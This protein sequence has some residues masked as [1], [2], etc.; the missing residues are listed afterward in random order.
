MAKSIIELGQNLDVV[1][2]RYRFG[3]DTNSEEIVDISDHMNVCHKIWLMHIPNSANDRLYV[4]LDGNNPISGNSM[5]F[6]LNG[7]V[8]ELEDISYSG[9]VNIRGSASSQRASIIC[10]G[11]N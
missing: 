7:D 5:I 1:V 10:W 9:V 8:L 11:K 2:H 6:E 3:V 4:S